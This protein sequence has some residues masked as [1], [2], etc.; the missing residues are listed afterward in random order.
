MLIREL[1]THLGFDVDFAPL[2]KFDAKIQ[3]TKEGLGQMESA[4]DDAVE[5]LKGALA[6][7]RNTL[8]GFSL[9]T[10]AGAAGLV[11]MVKSAANV[12]DEINKTA[13]LLGFSVEGFQ[14]YRYAAKLAGVEN[15]NFAGSIQLLLRNIAEARNGNKET[16]KSFARAGI[17]PASLAGLGTEEILRRLSDGLEKIPDQATK[18]SVSMDL[19]GRSGAR[20]GMF[21]AKG[22][23]EMD[24][25]MGDV[26]AFG[27]F[28]EESAQNAED[29][30]DSLERVLFFFSGI[31][32]EIGQG[33][34][35]VFTK[36]LNEFREWISQHRE[37]IK[38][39]L[40]TA[41]EFI[42]KAINK[43]WNATKAVVKGLETAI[44]LMGGYKNTLR[45]IGIAMLAVFLPLIGPIWFLIRSLGFLIIPFI[46]LH[47][48]VGLITIALSALMPL[49]TL[50]LS[51]AS[52]L[53]ATKIV[54]WLIQLAG[55][56]GALA[57]A[58]IVPTL[59]LIAQ[60]AALAAVILLFEDLTIW[61]LGGKSVIGEW[62]G[63]WSEIPTKL[64][65]IWQQIKDVFKEGGAFISAV[66]RGDWK[67]AARLF[68]DLNK[69]IADA[70]LATGEALAGVAKKAVGVGSKPLAPARPWTAAT[71]TGWGGMAGPYSFAGAPGRAAGQGGPFSSGPGAGT[72]AKSYVLGDV[73]D[74]RGNFRD[75]GG[76]SVKQTI[77]KVEVNVNLPQGSPQDH[78]EATARAFQD[79]LNQEVDHSLQQSV[80]PGG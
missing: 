78:A 1:V 29:L 25:L 30:N 3:D 58:I 12:G 54:G 63:A 2:N 65:A 23:A 27:M 73:L 45:L 48:L 22:T 38:A 59:A 72:F 19:L 53:V 13:P 41:I 67:E 9:A 5:S 8:I 61:M 40:A 6:K 47:T 17:N 36:I 14:K 57:A 75:Q 35:P 62:L 24:A 39:G 52:A 32:N 66:L 74:R 46:R 21:L 28:S 44:R 16:I 4:A 71:G 76:A 56:Y 42:T 33:L 77:G 20:M 64:R 11:A 69:P 34:M 10:A 51:V 43:A 26:E 60:A 68:L 15:E 31:K 50:F 7:I 37:V 80:P 18:V 70:A 55:G 79:L 49:W